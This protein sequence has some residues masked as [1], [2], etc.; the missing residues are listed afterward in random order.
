MLA[1]QRRAA[2]L[3]LVDQTGGVRVA[4]LVDRFGVSDMTIRRDI[5]QLASE[6]LVERVHGGALAVS[7]RSGVEP[8]FV[9]K[10]ELMTSE[11]QSIARTAA[12]LVAPGASIAISAGTTTAELARELRGVPDLTIVTNSVPVAQVMH[13]APAPDLRVVL[14][15]GMRTPSDALVGPVAVSS[16][17][18]LHVDML[19]LGVHG[20][21]VRAG[22]T[23]PNIS[24]A[25]TNRALVS[26][27]RRTCV[28]ADHTKWGV[29]GLATIVRLT[30][31]DLLVSDDG[32]P[33]R[34]RSAITDAGVELLVAERPRRPGSRAG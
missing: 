12:E 22:L 13:E 10:S 20:I 34:A 33:A 16:L 6:G 1:G 9:V 21:D 8:G 24:E 29:V 23:T 3:S 19:F 4:D 15:G 17:A 7:G 11:K 18:S 5:E 30:E 32:L 25:E 31:I 28:L 27:A 2:I 26:A 14:T